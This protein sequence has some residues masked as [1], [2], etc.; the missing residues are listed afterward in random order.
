MRR[1]SSSAPITAIPHRR[2][3]GQ[4]ASKQQG[5]RVLSASASIRVRSGRSDRSGS[6]Q[7][8]GTTAREE[9]WRAAEWR[10][11]CHRPHLTP[12]MAETESAPEEPQQQPPAPSKAATTQGKQVIGKNLFY[13]RFVWAAA[14]SIFSNMSGP[15]REHM[16][17]IRLFSLYS[18][19]DRAADAWIFALYRRLRLYQLIIY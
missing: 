6:G 12:S 15:R 14:A 1:L 18:W 11:S 13:W 5:R 9:D 2:L 4:R 17:L 7:E 10:T 8:L 19:F 16:A 3:P